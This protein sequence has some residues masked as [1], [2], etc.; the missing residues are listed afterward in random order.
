M[1]FYV[2]VYDATLKK[3]LRAHSIIGPLLHLIIIVCFIPNPP[4]VFVTGK[5]QF[6]LFG[7]KQTVPAKVSTDSMCTFVMVGQKVDSAY[8]LLRPSH[9][10][11]YCSSLTVS[12]GD[13]FAFL[14]FLLTV[15]GCYD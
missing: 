5:I 1:S 10:T 3:V 6:R 4:G 7:L 12:F 13:F 8:W 11:F 15:Q 9:A 14:I 2:R